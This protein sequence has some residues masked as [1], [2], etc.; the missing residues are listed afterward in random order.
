PDSMADVAAGRHVGAGGGPTDVLA[1]GAGAAAVLPGIGIRLR[2][3]RPRAVR[4]GQRLTLNGRAADRRS[5]GIGW[6]RRGRDR[7]RLG[8]RG[9]T[10]PGAVAGRDGDADG[11]RDVAVGERVGAFCGSGD[12]GAVGSRAV[13]VL[14][15]VGIRRGTVEPGS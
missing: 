12:V 15:L 5:S 2:V 9:G 11:V 3:V 4:G 7:R 14:P 1:V 8:R 10:R 6:G 13:T